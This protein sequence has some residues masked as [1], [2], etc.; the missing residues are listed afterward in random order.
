M[1]AAK[2]VRD[3][4]STGTTEVTGDLL[5]LG[6]AV[7][8]AEEDFQTAKTF[9][10]GRQAE[11]NLKLKE[12]QSEPDTTPDVAKRRWRSSG[13]YKEFIHS[14]QELNKLG[15]SLQKKKDALGRALMEKELRD[16]AN[17]NKEK[18][19]E[20]EPEPMQEVIGELD[21]NNYLDTEAMY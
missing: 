16:A 8:R 10:E 5:A 9:M 11:A 17:Q 3:A 14:S 19:K 21:N 20:K 15:Q 1:S 6:E 4:S 12:I 7:V 13:V 18:E 2:R